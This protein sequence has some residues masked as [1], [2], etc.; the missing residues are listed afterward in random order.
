MPFSWKCTTCGHATTVTDP[1]CKFGELD[2]FCRATAEDKGIK[3][4]ARLIECPNQDCKAQHFSVSVFHGKILHPVQRTDFVATKDLAPVGVG[5]FT[6]LPTTAQPLSTYVPQS[7]TDDYNE[8]YLIRTLSPKASATL[9]RR[10]LQGMIRD[11]WK[12]AHPTLHQELVAIKEKCD[13][14]LYEAMMGIKSIGNIGAHPEQD[15]NLIVD[16]EPGEAEAL[17]D[18]IHVLDQEWYVSRALREARIAKVKALSVEK[19]EAR[20]VKPQETAK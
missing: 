5:E 1:N 13:P 20:D 9:A 3:L 6:F 2:V 14:S 12:E 8:A 19:K 16:I 10:A 17:L 4:R 7:I 15:V 18:L 11:F